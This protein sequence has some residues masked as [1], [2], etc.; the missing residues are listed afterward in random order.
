MALAKNIYD[1][2][3]RILREEM[4]CAQ[5]CTEPIAIALCAALARKTL[6]K[7]AESILVETTGNMIKNV[8]SVHIP[9]A[10]GLIGIESAAIIG[11]VGGNADKQL[12]VLTELKPEHV[13]KTKELYEKGICK[14]KLLPGVPG[15]RIII[16]MK[17]GNDTAVVEIDK[18]HTNITRNELNGKSLIEHKAG[19]VTADEEKT[20]DLSVLNIHDCL[21]FSKEVNLADVQK[22][23]DTAI[24]CNTAIAEEGLK[25]DWGARVGKTLLSLK[26]GDD[27]ILTVMKAYSAAG[28]D[29]RMAG[30][31]MPV[32][33]NAGSGNQGITITMPVVK[34]AEYVGASKELLDRALVFANLVGIHQKTAIGVL[35][36]YCGAIS[37]A[38]GAIAGVAFIDGASEEVIDNTIISALCTLSGTICDGAKSSCATKIAGGIDAAWTAYQM[39]KNGDR[40]AAGDGICKTDVEKTIKAIGRLCWEGMAQTD[41]TILDILIG[42]DK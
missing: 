40:I 5:G 9:G 38:I 35:S 13:E 42:G 28:S 17:A 34:Y 11:M 24:N 2:Y 14:V 23:L 29:A 25:N 10:G 12:E 27:D 36:A 30:C 33:I 41:L 37:A 19:E 26:K 20:S 21:T 1:A 31:P 16:T 4:L 3:V 18:N 15:L 32:V 6:G 8:Q 39:A 22:E 7:D